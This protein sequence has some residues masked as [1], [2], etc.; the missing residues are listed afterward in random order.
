MGIYFSFVSQVYLHLSM[1]VQHCQALNFRIFLYFWGFEIEH[2][3][4]IGL[5]FAKINMSFNDTMGHFRCEHRQ[6]TLFKRWYKVLGISISLLKTI[7]LRCSVILSDKTQPK[8]PF[9]WKTWVLLTFILSKKFSLKPKPVFWKVKIG[10]FSVILDSFPKM[11]K[12]M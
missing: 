10:V 11:K 9:K 2:F 6:T 5:F 4:N 7:L 1:Y 3:C 8:N 12:L